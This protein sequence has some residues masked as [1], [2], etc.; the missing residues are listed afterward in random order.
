MRSSRTGKKGKSAL[1]VA[2]LAGCG[3]LAACS[4]RTRPEPVGYAEITSV[5]VDI[6]S[7]P[8][9]IYEGRPTYHVDDRWVYRDRGRWVYYRTEPRELYRQ[10]EYIQQAPRAPRYT[11]PAP[12]TP[13]PVRPAERVR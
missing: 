10:R 5:P 4:V 8:Y 12:R 3:L 2:L 7:R 6:E 9:V 13:P 1:S 11:T